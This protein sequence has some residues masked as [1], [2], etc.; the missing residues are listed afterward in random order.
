MALVG[1]SCPA[2][3]RTNGRPLL[4]E[5]KISGGAQGTDAPA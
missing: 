1:T 5:A 3:S 2:G 4:V